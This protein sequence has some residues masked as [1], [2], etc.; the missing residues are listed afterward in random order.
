MVDARGFSCPIPVVKTME[1]IKKD[2]PDSLEVLADDPCAV[3][4]ITRYGE[5][6][7]YSVSSSEN[8]GEYSIVLK[9]KA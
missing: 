7:G 1:A 8:D 9:K 2:A 5:N 3:E 6:N 4:N